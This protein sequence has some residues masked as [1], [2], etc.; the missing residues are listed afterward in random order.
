MKNKKKAFTLVE[1]IVII[2]LLAILWTISSIPI[3][4][5]LK[6][7]RDWKRISDIWN[8]KEVLSIYYMDKWVFPNP[9]NP[10][11]ITYNWSTIWTQW[12]II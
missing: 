7:A 10:E 3:M 5:Y 2:S 12:S 9:D 1:L 6:N 11:K 8:I 4:I